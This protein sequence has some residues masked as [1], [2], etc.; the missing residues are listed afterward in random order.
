MRIQ[1]LLAAATALTLAACTDSSTTPRLSPNG[2][3]K[4]IT[5]RSGYHIAT[6]EDG[7]ESCEPDG[8]T[9]FAPAQTAPTDGGS[10]ATPARP[11]TPAT[12]TSPAV[13]A[14]PATPPAT[15]TPDGAS[16]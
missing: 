4:D 10:T 11:A 9:F 15:A 8:D 14:T 3:T 2:A 7:S 1:L 6:R 16:E 13:P 5:C 12:P